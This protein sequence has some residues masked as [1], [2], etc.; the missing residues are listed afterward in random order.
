MSAAELACLRFT[1]GVA[2]FLQV[3]D[4]ERR[5]LEAQDGLS[6]GRTEAAAALV[7]VFEALGGVWPDDSTASGSGG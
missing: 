7:G 3:L 6:A 2:D 5:L 4:A 1:E